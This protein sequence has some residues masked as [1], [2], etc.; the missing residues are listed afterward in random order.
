MSLRFEKFDAS[1]LTPEMIAAAAE[2]FS[3]NYG[4]WGPQAAEKTDVK[5]LK[6]GVRVKCPQRSSPVR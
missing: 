1:T 3:Q 6:Q 4:V 2:L 5:R